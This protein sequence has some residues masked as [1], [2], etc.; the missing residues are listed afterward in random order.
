MSRLAS[1]S[2]VALLLAACTT[3]PAP[4]AGGD[5]DALAQVDRW[6]LQGAT[7]ADG[8]RI[9]AAFPVGTAVHAL[10]FDTGRVSVEGGCNRISGA[11]RIDGEGRLVID[12]LA[13]TR[14]ACADAALMAAD[15]AV[16]ELVQ[17][18]TE[19]RIAESWPEQLFLDHADGR[20][21][22]WVAD[23]D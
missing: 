10:S 13:S 4:S 7:D 17:G 9:D 20:R 22:A 23:R 16:S 11:Y 19:W 5:P 21:S 3:A 12:A 6:I 8:E 18:T 1:A 14:M 2:C 15:T